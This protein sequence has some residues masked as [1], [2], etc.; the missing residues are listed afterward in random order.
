M[1]EGETA[2]NPIT[3]HPATAPV[4]SSKL[5]GPGTIPRPLASSRTPVPKPFVNFPG[6][7]QVRLGKTHLAAIGIFLIILL[8]VAGLLLNLNKIQD[9][10]PGE[11]A[12]P[13]HTFTYS[14]TVQRMRDNKRYQQP[15]Q[16][17]G[18]EIFES[19]DKFRLNVSSS[20]PGYLYMF[21]EGPP[22]P[23]GSSFTIIYPTP[24]TNNGSATLGADQWVQTNWNTFTGQAG[25]ENFWIVWATSPVSQLESGKAEAF[26][27]EKGALT[28]ENLDVVK[29]FLMTKQSE[30]KTR[31]TTD[32]SSQQV[33]VRGTGD[34]LV[35]MVQFKHR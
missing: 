7:R 17:T 5:N 19:G 21:N 2:R 1:N 24:A 25:T 14:L 4:T 32:K 22:E 13:T 10:P 23:A 12:G 15:F 9:E 27:H 29:S 6:D 30:V 16:S 11:S 8:G 18:L 31:Y 3:E 28:D 34:V 20:H 35:R 26:K 33:T